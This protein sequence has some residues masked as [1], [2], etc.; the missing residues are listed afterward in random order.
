[1]PTRFLQPLALVALAILVVIGCDPGGGEQPRTL[2]EQSASLQS[3]VTREDS[4]PIEPVVYICPM[5]PNIVA[6]E[7]GVC[8]I[9]GMDLQLSKKRGTKG[10]SGRSPVELAPEQRQLIN[11]R[12]AR[13]GR[14]QA[15]KTIRTVG[16]MKQ[17]ESAVATVSAWTSGR[18]EKLYVDRTETNVKKGQRLYSIY[19]PDLYSTMQEYVG[20]LTNQSANTQLI[21]ATRTRLALLGLSDEQLELLGDDRRVVPTIDVLSQVAGR[22]TRLD[23][24][25]GSYV[26]TGDPMYTIADLSRLWLIVTIY[27]FELGLIQPGMRVVATSLALPDDEFHGRITL[28]NHKIEQHARAAEIRVEFDEALHAGDEHGSGRYRNALAHHLLPD[29]YMDVE[30][31]ID[32]GEQLVVPASA[33]FDTGDR[34]YVFVEQDEGLFVPREVRLGA[35]AG[36][37]FVVLEGLDSGMEVVVDGTFLLDSES[38]FRGAA[39]GNEP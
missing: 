28:I 23:A 38:Q 10:I 29:M 8:P 33:V 17:D 27:E 14:V 13:I 22:V 31:E 32:L 2:S 20:L 26:K 5:H 34:D 11:L 24:N 25:Q 21:A 3:S 1:M 19:S 37:Q 7:P 35:K 6:D 9:C 39:E 18:I 12:T 4:H 36:N 15:R 30:I 16:I